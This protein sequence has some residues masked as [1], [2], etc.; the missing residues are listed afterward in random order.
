MVHAAVDR[1]VE[2][3]MVELDQFEAMNLLATDNDNTRVG[4]GGFGYCDT[5]PGEDFDPAHV[6]ARNMW[7]CSNAQIFSGVSPEMHWDF[8]LAHDMRWLTRFGLTYYGCCEP[9]DGKLDLMRR[10]P[11]LRKI[12][13]SP[14]CDMERIAEGV[15]ADY[16]IS[17]KP[18]PAVFAE[19][20]WRP[21]QARADLRRVLDIF[22]DGCRVEL[23]MKDISTVRYEPERLWEWARIAMEEV[24]GA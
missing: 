12:S 19:E 15:G 8:A 9:L 7:G 24:G 23:I 14:W 6:R 17:H 4:S 3:W 1:M 13:V 22:G 10:I 16:V 18:N 5:L 11:N 2:A 20:R 21:E